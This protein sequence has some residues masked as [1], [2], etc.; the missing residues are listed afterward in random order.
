MSDFCRRHSSFFCPCAK[1]Y[2]YRGE[3]ERIESWGLN[4]H[5]VAV[6]LA[7]ADGARDPDGAGSLAERPWP[8]LMPSEEMLAWALDKL[9]S[10]DLASTNDLLNV[11][12]PQAR[13]DGYV[14]EAV[15]HAWLEQQG[16]Q[17]VWN[18]GADGLPDF[19]IG[20][21]EVAFR[22]CAT[23]STLSK[24]NYLYIFKAQAHGVQQRFFGYVN[25]STGRHYLVGGITLELF[26]QK[27][28]LYEIG[29]ELQPGFIVR[30]PMYVR[31]VACLTEPADWLATI[32]DS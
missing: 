15:F 3:R 11:A 27:A 9:R 29:E 24:L 32:Y 22:S 13:S 10:D 16:V 31:S 26:L 4:E 20:G 1:P 6:V 17:H 23:R 14:G 12:D 8:H 30:H 19:V 2:L 7:R 18:G 28:R 5:E 21:T 25:R